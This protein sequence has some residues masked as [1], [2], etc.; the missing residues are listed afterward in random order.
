M[1]QSTEYD[2]LFKIL[3]VGK[4]QVGKTNLLMQYADHS[5]T[6]SYMTT[7]GVDFRVHSLQSG[8][9]NIKLQIWDSAG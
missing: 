7:I 6:E 9:R 2:Y 1:V 4:D 3:M 5:Y 8:N